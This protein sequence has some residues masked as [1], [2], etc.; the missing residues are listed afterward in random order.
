[1]AKK[2]YIV[3]AAVITVITAAIIIMVCS[4]RRGCLV[5]SDSETKK[6]IKRFEADAG[7]RFSIEFVHSV[8]KSIVRD[9][10]E[11][12][13]DGHIY[14]VECVYYAFGAGVQTELNEGEELL[15][16]EDGSMII[17]GINKKTDNMSFIIGTI[18]DHVLGYRG[19]KI[20]LT[21]LCGRNRHVCFSYE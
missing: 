12:R 6:V 15:R 9:I 4:G 7:E 19:E 18:Y 11:L 13:D 20:S 21:E 3:V 14:N 16:G 1:M 2:V 8:N 10:Y 17:T 5:L